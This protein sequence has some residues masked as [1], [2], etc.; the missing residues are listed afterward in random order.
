[1][2]NNW[3]RCERA[4]IYRELGFWKSDGKKEGL[5]IRRTKVQVLS[6]LHVNSIIW[7]NYIYTPSSSILPI[8]KDI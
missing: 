8:G 2:R 4:Q 3:P 1:M 7:G 6:F 5:D